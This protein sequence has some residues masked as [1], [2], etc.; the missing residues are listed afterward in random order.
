M[1]KVITR[2]F[3]TCKTKKS[4]EKSTHK[5]LCMHGS[6][7][8]NYGNQ[9]IIFQQTRLTS[10]HTL[11]RKFCHKRVIFR[12]FQ[13]SSYLK[14]LMTWDRTLSP[15]SDNLFSARTNSMKK[16]RWTRSKFSRMMF[17]SLMLE[18]DSRPLIEALLPAV[19]GMK[20]TVNYFIKSIN[21]LV[22]Q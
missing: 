19:K 6:H 11:S 20:R 12:N 18:N 5:I 3:I 14:T 16:F 8:E 7:Y 22:T 21:S 4:M 17:V 10:S 13:I 15:I 2:V 9:L 1:T